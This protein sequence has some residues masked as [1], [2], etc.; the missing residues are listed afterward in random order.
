MTTAIIGVGNL[1]SALAR[2]L[3]LEVFLPA[4]AYHQIGIIPAGPCPPARTRL[5][6]ATH[7]GEW[8]DVGRAYIANADGHRQSREDR[9]R[10]PPSPDR[11]R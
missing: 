2:N 11:G 5:L 7:L 8:D 3:V 10:L 4:T 6:A 9:H 1:G